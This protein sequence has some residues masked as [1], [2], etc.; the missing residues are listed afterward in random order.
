MFVQLIINQIQTLT[1]FLCLSSSWSLSQQ[2]KNVRPIANYV[3][4]R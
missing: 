4:I 2:S 3:S 1:A